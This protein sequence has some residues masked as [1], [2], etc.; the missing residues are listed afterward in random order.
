MRPAPPRAPRCF[1]K[2]P[3]EL[4]GSVL[5]TLNGTA[6]AAAGAAGSLAGSYAGAGARLGAHVADISKGALIVLAAGLGAGV[7]LSLVR[8]A[9]GRTNPAGGGAA[10]LGSLTPVRAAP[11]GRGG[12]MQTA[13]APARLRAHA[14]RRGCWCSATLPASWRGRPSSP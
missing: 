9:A 1:P 13:P 2:F 5:S 10:P 3:E 11:A 4:M 14:L 8:G 6:G 12:C 7:A